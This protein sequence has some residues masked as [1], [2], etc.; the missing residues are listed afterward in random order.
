MPQDIPPLWLHPKRREGDARADSID[1]SVAQPGDDGLLAASGADRD[2]AG[3]SVG[4][5]RRDG[6]RPGGA[7]PD[8]GDRQPADGAGG[9]RTRPA[10][11][12]AQQIGRHTSELQSLMRISY[13][14]F[15]LKK[16]KTTKQT[17]TYTQHNKTTH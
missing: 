7:D 16:K 5:G 14:V 2:A 17:I 12:G 13:A 8:R 4:T 10:H 3:L 9:G 6:G 1:S 15:C 11:P